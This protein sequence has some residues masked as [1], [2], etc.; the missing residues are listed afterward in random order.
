MVLPSSPRVSQRSS[1]RC[2][3]RLFGELGLLHEIFDV[4]HLNCRIEQ[5]HSGSFIFALGLNLFV[6]RPDL[7]RQASFEYYMF[8]ARETCS[9]VDFVP[10]FWL[11][12]HIRSVD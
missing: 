10:S 7:A 11:E 5:F 3:E 9:T 2:F 12:S 1:R 8:H 4:G 6:H